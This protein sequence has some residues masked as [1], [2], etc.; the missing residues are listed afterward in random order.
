MGKH[1]VSAAT[2]SLLYGLDNTSNNKGFTRTSW[3]DNDW[4][5]FILA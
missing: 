3:G 4:I 2:P 5:A 1:H